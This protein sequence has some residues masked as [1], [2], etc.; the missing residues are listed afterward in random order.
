LYYILNAST[1]RRVYLGKEVRDDKEKAPLGLISTS[2][3]FEVAFATTVMLFGRSSG[4]ALAAVA[5]VLIEVPVML[6]L[7]GICKRTRHL[8][9]TRVRGTARA[10]IQAAAE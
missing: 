9:P 3:H 6:L 2:K 1:R 10:T 5:R 8:F 4:A 7:V